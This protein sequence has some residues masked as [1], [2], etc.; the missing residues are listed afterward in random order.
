MLKFGWIIKILCP[1]MFDFFMGKEQVERSPFL[2][3]KLKSI[4]F[5]LQPWKSTSSVLKDLPEA[6]SSESSQQLCQNSK[7]KI[8]AYLPCPSKIPIQNYFGAKYSLFILTLLAPYL[9][10]NAIPSAKFIFDKTQMLGEK[11]A[12]NSVKSIWTIKKTAVPELKI[13]ICHNLVVYIEL[14]P[15]VMS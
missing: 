4:I 9:Y 6:K 3:K 12:Q 1:K 7:Y 15:L 5:S 10:E 11:Y 14:F 8:L 13:L 2:R